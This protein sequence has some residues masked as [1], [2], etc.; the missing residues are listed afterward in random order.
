MLYIIW[1]FALNL[2]LH[3][4]VEALLAL[5]ERLFPSSIHLVSITPLQTNQPFKC[6]DS[7]STTLVWL[8]LLGS[9]SWHEATRRIGE[10]VKVLPCRM[11]YW[12]YV[13]F[14]GFKLRVNVYY[15]CIG[16]TLDDRHS[17]WPI[18][19]KAHIC[20]WGTHVLVSQGLPFCCP[21]YW[22]LFYFTIRLRNQRKWTFWCHR[23]HRVSISPPEHI[24]SLLAILTS[25]RSPGG[26]LH[27]LSGMNYAS[28]MCLS[29]GGGLSMQ[30][31]DNL[32][33]SPY[34]CTGREH[35]VPSS[36]IINPHL[37][38]YHYTHLHIYDSC[39]WCTSPVD[40][41]LSYTPLTSPHFP[42]SHLM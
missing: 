33:P 35:L 37:Y 4:T 13:L 42:P 7:T 18:L 10:H 29:Y 22:A 24:F 1:F 11:K 14:V 15:W 25:V 16:W 23:S 17:V 5:G 20:W 31:S 8:Y 36:P 30:L 27:W 28:L 21:L 3:Q 26:L 12:I 19:S 32:S 39:I 38:I 9:M 34:R 41:I 2:L 6:V 40:G